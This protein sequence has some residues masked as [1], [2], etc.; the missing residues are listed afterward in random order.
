MRFGIKRSGDSNFISNH[1]PTKRSSKNHTKKGVWQ[2]DKNIS[3]K[4]ELLKCFD[5]EVA[6]GLKIEYTMNR[7]FYSNFQ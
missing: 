3:T 1:K 7:A 5:F 6:Q 4:G 2:P